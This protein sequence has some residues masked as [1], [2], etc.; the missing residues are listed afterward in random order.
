MHKRRIISICGPSGAGKSFLVKKFT[1]YSRI[2]T[3]DFYIGK[4]QMRPDAKGVYNF[5]SPDAV[6]LE[7][8]GAVVQELATLPPG[9]E[10][11]MPRYNMKTSERDGTKIKIVPDLNAIIIIE[12][13]FAFHPPLLKMSDFRIFMD[14]PPEVI[15]ARRYKRDIEERG[16]TPVDILKQYPMVIKGYE[17]FIE[18]VRRF[19]DLIIDFGVLI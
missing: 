8:C 9:A 10:V 5:D 13:I 11:N 16:R 19:A 18:P 14:P 6:D 3:D 1:N 2:S 15:L 17:E 7:E 12:G 4:S